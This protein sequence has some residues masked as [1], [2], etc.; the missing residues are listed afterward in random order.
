M[1]WLQ[2]ELAAT[3]DTAPALETALEAIGAVSVTMTDAQDQPLYEP[4]PGETPLWN[5]IVV[6]GLFTGDTRK[7]EMIMDLAAELLPAS[8]PAFKTE[9]LEE[10]NWQR[11]WMDS[12]QPMRFGER[13]WICPSWT[14]APDPTAVNLLLDPGLAFGTGT[15]P[16]TALCLQWLDAHDVRGQTL[17]DYGCGSGILGIA[18]LLLGAERVLGVDNDPQALVATR[19]N[20]DKNS[21]SAASF[22]AVLPAA[23]PALMGTAPEGQVDGVLANILAAPLLELAAD[24]AALVKPGGWL[25][26][27]GILQEQAPLIVERYREWFEVDEPVFLDGWT[28]ISAQRKDS[29]A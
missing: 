20:C 22:P 12:F 13:L 16:T 7:E 5:D 1:S 24:I 26:L 15:H 28:R 8:L 19:D 9:I 2:I 27:S 21:I 17:V 4:G 10:Q 25:L 14:E 11:A 29:P 23:F 3:A 18:A 6:T